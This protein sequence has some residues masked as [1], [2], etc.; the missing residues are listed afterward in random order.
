M[1][2]LTSS[3][4]VIN[5]NK[6]SNKSPGPAHEVLQYTNSGLRFECIMCAK[7]I[8]KLYE[9]ANYFSLIIYSS[10][11]L[12]SFSLISHSFRAAAMSLACLA[13]FVSAQSLEQSNSLFKKYYI[14]KI[15]FKNITCNR[16]HSESPISVLWRSRWSSAPPFR[17][18]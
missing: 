15:Q 11:S 5:H 9:I 10:G 12:T 14:I 4:Q 1:Y 6:L 17:V 8:K 2:Q 16:G 13:G 7:C 3:L 18:F